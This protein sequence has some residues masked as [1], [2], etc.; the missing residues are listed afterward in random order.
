M[1]GRVV[2]DSVGS[3]RVLEKCGFRICREDKGFA[4]GRGCEVEE[5]VL[6]LEP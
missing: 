1:F 4:A 3:R 6:V 2:K 5:Y